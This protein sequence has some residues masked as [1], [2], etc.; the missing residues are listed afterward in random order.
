MENTTHQYEN[1][2]LDNL[3]QEIKNIVDTSHQRE[4]ST[5]EELN[6][7]EDE[8]WKDAELQRMHTKL[9]ILEADYYRGFP[10]SKDAKDATE[11]WMNDHFA[12]QHNATT[13]EDIMRTQGAIGGM[14]SYVFV[15]TSIGTIGVCRCAQCYKKAILTVGNPTS[16]PSYGKYNEALE[17][18]VKYY[19][20]EYVF[21]D[22]Y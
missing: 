4:V 17:K 18:A 3:F 20:A 8:K 16:Y 13:T 19:D 21:Q 12:K 2:K 15:P 6:K 1:I 10:I 14:F 11:C 5:K 7:V 9:N 22:L